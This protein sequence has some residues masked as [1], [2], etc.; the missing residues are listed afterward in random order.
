M[1]SAQPDVVKRRALFCLGKFLGLQ[2]PDFE[3]LASVV[4]SEFNLAAMFPTEDDPLPIHDDQFARNET[5]ILKFH[6][7]DLALAAQ[8]S[9]I[10]APGD[11]ARRDE[12]VSSDFNRLDLVLLLHDSDDFVK[13][14]RVMSDPLAF[15]I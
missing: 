10:G 4:F 7:G 14:P 12:I 15:Q 6:L 13:V 8:C 3:T 5:W 9:K 11:C 1:M 2:V